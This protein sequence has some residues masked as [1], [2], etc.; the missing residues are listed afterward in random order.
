MSQMDIEPPSRSKQ[1]IAPKS[2]KRKIEQTFVDPNPK[3]SKISLDESKK[4][5]CVNALF[6]AFQ[7]LLKVM[8]T[9]EYP[10]EELL[11]NLNVL[12]QITSVTFTRHN[13]K[14]KLQ[15]TPSSNRE[16]VARIWEEAVAQQ[17]LEYKNFSL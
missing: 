6:C 9:E 4:R 8:C 5:R 15:T 14:R 13:V 11:L 3:R 2:A 12:Y 7:D 17:G 10:Y 1:A 16:H